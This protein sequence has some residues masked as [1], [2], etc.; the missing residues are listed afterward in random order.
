METLNEA[1][2]VWEAKLCL[3]LDGEAGNLSELSRPSSRHLLGSRERQPKPTRRKDI[4]SILLTPKQTQMLQVQKNGEIVLKD[5][6][7]CCDHLGL[8]ILS[9][10][11]LAGP[12][13]FSSCYL[14]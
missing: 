14:G 12:F 13:H 9:N 5:T 1:G 4:F 6:D 8:K 7:S 3:Q 2:L 10:S 11:A